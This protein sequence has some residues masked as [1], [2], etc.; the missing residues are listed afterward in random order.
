M[1]PPVER[2]NTLLVDLLKNPELGRPQET[3][4]AVQPYRSGLSL[5]YVGRPSLFAGSNQFGT[6]IGGGATLYFSDVWGITTW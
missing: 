4:F 2:R 1:L 6:F 5:T 3:E